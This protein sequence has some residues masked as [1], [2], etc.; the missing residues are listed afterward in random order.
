MTKARLK[1][2]EVRVKANLISSSEEKAV[3]FNLLPFE[4][5]D[6]FDQLRGINADLLGEDQVIG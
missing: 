3:Y 6:R 4:L 5:I 1:G 2:I